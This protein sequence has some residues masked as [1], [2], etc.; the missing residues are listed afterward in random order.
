MTEM[1]AL[2]ERLVSLF[3]L[4]RRPAQLAGAPGKAGIMIAKLRED[5]PQFGMTN[6]VP[7][8]DA[9][10]VGLLPSDY[11]HLRVWEDGRAEP[12]TSVKAGDSVFFDLR[13]NPRF[14]KNAPLG[15]MVFYLPR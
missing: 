7:E 10:M 14:V 5:D 11:P 2:S 4:R 1:G 8:D 13:R 3:G 15:S 12:A 6:P 9:Y